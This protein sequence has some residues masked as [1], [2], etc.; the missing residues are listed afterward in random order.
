MERAALPMVQ[1]IE[2]LLADAEPSLADVEETLTQGYATALAIDAERLRI[3]RRLGEVA[4]NATADQ[5][6]EIRQLG[7]QL[8]SAD[9]ELHR[10][11]TVLVTLRDRA[12]VLRAAA[13]AS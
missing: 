10:L 2:D 4:R 9:G 6:A 1:Q 12:R 8:T 5:A 3:E 13:A 7:T 11:R